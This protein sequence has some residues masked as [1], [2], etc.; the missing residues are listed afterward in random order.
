MAKIRQLSPLEAQ[1]IAAGEVVERPA[2]VVK[3]LIENALDAGASTITL[4]LENAGKTLIRCVDNGSGMSSEDARAC[5]LHHATSKITSVDDLDSLTTFG[6]R[7]E[8][9]SSIASVSHLSIT[10]RESS[11]DS[12]VKLEISQG[13]ITEESI[14]AA[15]IGTDIAITDLFFN[16]PARKKFLKAKET[17]WRAIINLFQAMC[18]AY[19]EVSFKLYHEDRLVYNHPAA[20]SLSDRTAQLFESSLV[21][22]ILEHQRS[23]ETL[24]VH[25]AIACTTP[26]YTRFD[27]NQIFVFVNKRWVKNYKLTQAFIKGYTGML[28]PLKYPA[29]CIFI[30][31]DPHSIDV[32]IHPRKEEVHFTHPRIIESLIESTVHEKLQE[33]HADQ[34]GKTPTTHIPTAHRASSPFELPS[35]QGSFK[36]PHSSEPM[37]DSHKDEKAFLDLITPHFNHNTAT[38]EMTVSMAP[39]VEQIPPSSRVVPP[40][41]PMTIP[42]TTAPASSMN[43]KL[44]GQLA[45]TY[46]LIETDKGLVLVD[47]HAAHERIL[48]ER[49]KARFENPDRIRL[50]VPQIV[51]LTKEDAALFE[52]HLPLLSSFGIDAQLISDHQL[53]IQETSIYAKNISIEECIQ[54]AVSALHEHSSLEEQ[55]LKKILHERIH[56]S[57]SCK[58]AVKAGDTLSHESMHRLITDLSTTEN[59]LSC[60]HGRPTLWELTK[61]EIEKKFKRDYR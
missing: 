51:V 50:I 47:Q 60:P 54:Q 28:Q 43:F 2:N 29:G 39:Q 33:M 42:H 26:S 56:A 34:L 61:S 18:L 48:Y 1:K 11:T 15:T 40:L 24:E 53:S 9:L 46:I 49:F 58:T 38:P 35:F 41:A 59:R 6:F 37:V 5:I 44:L 16:V 10:T 3:E 32:N 8:A 27:R 57:M 55:E 20:S 12:G 13:T 30:T 25:C 31:L 45:L 21:K 23:H 36:L 52:P 19:K 17:E 22:N 14:V 7:G 4:Y